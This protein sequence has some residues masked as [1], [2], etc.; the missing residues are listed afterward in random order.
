MHSDYE[1]LIAKLDAFIRKFYKDR[2][3][4][5]LLYS[6][7]LVVG[8]FL[9][10]ALLESIGTGKGDAGIAGILPK[11]HSATPKNNCG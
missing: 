10:A 9:L 6:I 7:G 11:M 4:R 2:F 1:H 5:G 8:V 3:I